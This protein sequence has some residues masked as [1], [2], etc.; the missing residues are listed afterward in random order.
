MPFRR[1]STLSRSALA[2]DGVEVLYF[3]SGASHATIAIQDANH[4]LGEAP[5][6]GGADGADEDFTQDGR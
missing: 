6:V 4:W 5:T 3:F 1:S 2:L